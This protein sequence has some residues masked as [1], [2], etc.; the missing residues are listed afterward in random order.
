MIQLLV[1]AS[2]AN[3]F[4]VILLAGIVAVV[5]AL[6]TARMPIDVFPDLTAPTVTVLAEARGMTPLEMEAQVTFPIESAMNGAAEVRRVRSGTTLGIAVVWVEFEWGTDIHR[7][8]QTVTERLATV[9]GS[10]PP[11]VEPPKLAPVS[12][13]LGEIL[14]V[15][16][17]SDRHDGLELRTLASSRLRR[18][19][20]AVPG[21]SQV[22]PIGGDVR[23]Y[24]VVLSPDKL[25][26]LGVAPREV[27]EALERANENVAAGVLDEGPRELVIEGLG[28]VRSVEDLEDATVA[29]RDG[30]TVRVRDVGLVRVGAAPRRGTAAASCREEDGSP[31]IRDGIVLAIQKQ[32]QA[33]TLELTE[34]LER[35]LGELAG[36]L[37]EGMHLDQGLFRQ[38]TFIEAALANTSLALLEGAAMVTLVVLLFLASARA[39]LVTLVALPLSLLTA[40]LVLRALGDSINTMTLGGMAIAIGALVDDAIIDVENVVRRLREDVARPVGER[41]GPLTVVYEAS[42]EVRASIVLA[43]VLILLVF[44]PLFFLSGVEGRLLR[45]LGVA[46]CVALAA[47][48]L[49]ALTLTPALCSLV[50]PRSRTVRDGHDS[51]FVALL[52][53]LYRGPLEAV[54][55]RPLLVVVPAVAL[56]VLA[57]GAG[58][59]LGRSFLPEFNEGALVIGIVTLPGTSL[60]Q[61]HALARLAEEGLMRHPEVVAIGRRTGRAEE[62]EHVQ[63]VEASEIELTLDMEAPARFGLPRRTRAELLEA[64]RAELAAVPGIQATF[65]QPIGHRIDHMLS[66]TRASV[67]VK[68]SGDDLERLRSL[69]TEVE[70]LMRTVPGV[71]D[72]AAEQQVLVPSLRIEFDRA[73]L[74]RHALTVGDAA[75][76]LRLATTGIVAGRVLEGLEGLDLVVRLGTHEQLDADV[77]RATSVRAPGGER[78]PL[79]ALARIVEDRTPN[80]I[81]RED[82][83]RMLGV[84][85]NVAGRDVGSVVDDV[86]ARVG[87]EVELPAGYTIEYGGQFESASATA[88]L[89]SL[90]GGLIV[91]AIAGLLYRLFRS[92]RDTLLVL[93]NLPLAVIGGVAGVYAS[94]GV[95]SVA[96]LIGFITVLGVAARNGIMLVSH[97]RHL[98]EAEGV[99]DFGEAVRR[100]AL[101]RLAPILMTALA[102]GLALVPLAAR[103]GEPGNE[104]LAPMAAVILGGLASSTLLN[105]L[106]VPALFLR[107]GRPRATPSF[108]PEVSHA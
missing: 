71:V 40:V 62:D 34:R 84:T 96:S 65:G 56:V 48:L 29:A 106:L 79:A 28:R 73:A 12:S 102:A 17:T 22:T 95:L 80:F 99:T 38:A 2:L 1:R 66:G 69:G 97:V 83:R 31:R 92:W 11:E 51:R 103:G 64:L 18:R 100:G 60:A 101:E 53:R 105:L 3:R 20:L 19:L 26:A 41:R 52:K 37:P 54:L 94:D 32:P 25:A 30:L 91:L 8:R 108:Q 67:A 16:L 61:S 14:F 10:L 72:L 88:R 49:T 43:T 98:Q 93:V 75:E 33:N 55:R 81:R 59:R 87:R 77:L 85:C 23:E 36:E 50:L 58:A 46:F 70:A 5:G 90:L 9:S 82:V 6:V 45:P 4:L 63:G 68:I 104:I 39:S 42:L 21:V 15:S 7:A 86:R 13:I 107:F 24:Q 27:V 35:V 44:T 89:L 78:V 76:A 57:A 74:G 47:S